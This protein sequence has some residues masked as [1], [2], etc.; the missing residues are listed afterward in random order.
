MKAS[1]L[2]NE[3]KENLKDFN[4]EY[5]RNKA[6]DDRYKDPLTKQLAKYNSSIYDEI[7]ELELENDFEIPNKDI[8]SLKNDIDFYFS[9]YDP[10]DEENQK[11]TKNISLYL[12]FIGKKPLHPFGEGGNV[13]LK[14]GQYYCKGR[15]NYIKDKNSLC[16]YCPTK[17]A[18]FNHFF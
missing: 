1:K 17:V 7:F 18:P 12:S 10:H 2:L 15:A 14:N 11:L 6:T 8:Q 13:Y 9:R 5:V 4:I 16:R 3:I